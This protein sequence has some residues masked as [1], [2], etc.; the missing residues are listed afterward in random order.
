MFIS[1]ALAASALPVD[2]EP[3]SMSEAFLY[4]AGFI[5]LVVV[6]FYLIFILPQQ[7]RMAA[8]SE[9]LKGLKKGDKVMTAGG[10]VGVISNLKSDS[11]IEV[12]LGDKQVVTVLRSY[13]DK[14]PEE[15]ASAPLKEKD[16]K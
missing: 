11:E 5:L 13:V 15:T 12:D 16:K 7:K 14:M 9:M 3:P 6:V 2:A 10:L 1:T 8:Q 4:N